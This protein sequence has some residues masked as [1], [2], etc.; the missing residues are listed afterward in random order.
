MVNTGILIKQYETP[1]PECYTVFWRMT[2]CSDTLRLSDVTSI[3]DPVT[4][5]DLITEFE[6]LPN[7]AGFQQ[8]ICNGCGMS[9]EDAYSSVHLVQCHFV[10]CICSNVETNLFRTC[11]FP[12]V[13]VSYI[14]RYLCFAFQVFKTVA[15]L[16]ENKYNFAK[17]FI[18]LYW[19]K[20][21]KC[22]TMYM[23]LESS[24]IS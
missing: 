21:L 22:S 2:I 18:E 11:L 20:P 16:H 4:D 5:L 19:D 23:Y 9:T 13:R 15:E 17:A 10:T 7:C 12:D 8:N 1:F 6:F 14:S 3:Y 24:N